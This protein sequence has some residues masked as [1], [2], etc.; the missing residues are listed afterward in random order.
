M[1]RKVKDVNKE[2]INRLREKYAHVLNGR[3]EFNI[4]KISNFVNL[5]IPTLAEQFKDQTKVR[6][7]CLFSVCIPHKRSYQTKQKYIQHLYLKHSNLLPGNGIFLLNNDNN[8][9]VNGFWCSK[10]GKNFQRKDHLYSH[11]RKVVKCSNGE[12]MIIDPGLKEKQQRGKKEKE[13]KTPVES[14]IIV[15]EETLTQCSLVDISLDVQ[16]KNND[17]IICLD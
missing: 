13:I 8:M 16:E 7:N 3:L 15:L 1:C 5:V 9:C 10:C 2:E 12:I 6:Y 17:S 14:D 4:H 11:F